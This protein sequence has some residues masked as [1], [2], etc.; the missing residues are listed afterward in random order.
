M[1]KTFST[2]TVM[3]PPDFVESN[4]HSSTRATTNRPLDV[5]RSA[6]KPEE[7]GIAVL[8]SPGDADFLG[9]PPI[10]S[11]GRKLPCVNYFWWLCK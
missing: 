7:G 5:I 9:R 2:A 10:I 1:P 6:G 11:P 3:T 8:R 4:K